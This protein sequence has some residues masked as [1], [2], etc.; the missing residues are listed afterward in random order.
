MLIE[1]PLGNGVEWYNNSR[2]NSWHLCQEGRYQGPNRDLSPLHVGQY[3]EQHRTWTIERVWIRPVHGWRAWRVDIYMC[4]EHCSKG[5]AWKGMT[6]VNV[7]ERRPP[8]A[9]ARAWAILSPCRAAAVAGA[10]VPLLGVDEW[11]IVDKCGLHTI[12]H[13]VSVP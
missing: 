6:Y 10:I 3:D 9:P 12:L 5:K 8:P 4:I 2:Q 1:R 13:T 11:D 7:M